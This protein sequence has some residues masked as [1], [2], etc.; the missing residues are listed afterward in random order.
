MISR[1][2]LAPKASSQHTSCEALISTFTTSHLAP[3]KGQ[4]RH[5]HVGP[6]T[7]PEATPD[8][9]RPDRV[10][11]LPRHPNRAR[12]SGVRWEPDRKRR[13]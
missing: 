4:P 5:C 12:S 8:T 10:I 11:G 7:G 3:L 1:N 13:R 2:V 6:P 9:A